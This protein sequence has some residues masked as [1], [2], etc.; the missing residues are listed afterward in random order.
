MYFMQN[1]CILYFPA[2]ASIFYISYKVFFFCQ[3]T[4][5]EFHAKYLCFVFFL[6]FSFLSHIM[7]F[8]CICLSCHDDE[9][10]QNNLFGAIGFFINLGQ[11]GDDQLWMVALRGGAEGHGQCDRSGRQGLEM[12]IWSIKNISN[13]IP[14]LLDQDGDGDINFHE[15]VWLMTRSGNKIFK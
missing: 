10:P 8:F 4:V 5:F 1:I 15:F 7:S 11:P 12:A 3:L 6:F 9:P 14:S 13:I 2:G